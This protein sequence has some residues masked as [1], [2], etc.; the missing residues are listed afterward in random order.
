SS[1][2]LTNPDCTDRI[3]HRRQEPA[4]LELDEIDI[5]GNCVSLCGACISAAR[6]YCILIVVS[7]MRSGSATLHPVLGYVL[8]HTYGI[9]RYIYTDRS[10]SPLCL[11]KKSGWIGKWLWNSKVSNGINL[12]F[13]AA[14]EYFQ[15]CWS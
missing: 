10:R 7:R 5:V 3:E 15:T 2:T 8:K 11:N 9:A 1:I 12:M 13:F 6:K 14:T 4:P